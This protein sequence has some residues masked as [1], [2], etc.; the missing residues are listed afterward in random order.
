MVVRVLFWELF[1]DPLHRRLQ[2]FRCL[3]DCSDYFRLADCASEYP[4]RSIPY[5][6]RM[7]RL[8]Q[9]RRSF[10]K[11]SR[12]SGSRTTPTCLV[13][14]ANSGN[15][16]LTR[17]PSF[18]ADFLNRHSEKLLFGGHRIYKLKS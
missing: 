12:T 3:H 11:A 7:T 9:E 1:G 5:C 18:T 4:E 15:N 6:P 13:I 14:S 17:D 10:V 16:A 2:P 8:I